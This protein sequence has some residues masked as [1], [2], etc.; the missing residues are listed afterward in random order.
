MTNI[1]FYFVV[2]DFNID[3]PVIRSFSIFVMGI[4][5]EFCTSLGHHMVNIHGLTLF[6]LR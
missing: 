3:V 4:A 1:G 2:Q 6:C 5:M